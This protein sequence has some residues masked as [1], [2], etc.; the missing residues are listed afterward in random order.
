MKEEEYGVPQVRAGA[1][2]A[3]AANQIAQVELKLAQ[4]RVAPLLT[5]AKAVPSMHELGLA[6]DLRQRIDCAIFAQFERPPQFPSSR[7]ALETALDLDEDINVCDY[8]GDERCAVC[9]MDP[10]AYIQAKH[11]I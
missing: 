3:P 8:L 6:F 11:G 4:Q 10:H 9:T 5:G 7:M 1:P 2:G